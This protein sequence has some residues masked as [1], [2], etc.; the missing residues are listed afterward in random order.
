M[1]L[2]DHESPLVNKQASFKNDSD[3]NDFSKNPETG[4]MKSREQEVST[5]FFL[6]FNIHN[7]K[8]YS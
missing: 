3:Y 6:E 5:E 2:S 4:F 7:F 1:D 8:R